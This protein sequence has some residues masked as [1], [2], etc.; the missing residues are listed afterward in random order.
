MKQYTDYVYSGT[1]TSPKIDI[2]DSSHYTFY[3]PNDTGTGSL[4]RGLVI[5]DLVVLNNTKLPAVIH[6]T[7]ILKHIEDDTLEKLIELYNNSPKQVFI[8]FDRDTTYS[9]K[10]QTILNDSKV[11]KL[12]SGGN[13]LFGR[14]WNEIKKE[15]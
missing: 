15:E 9:E 7:V 6:D 3:T 12:S 2:I 5:F 8:A 10:M 1:K 4:C 11:L 13:E 14:A